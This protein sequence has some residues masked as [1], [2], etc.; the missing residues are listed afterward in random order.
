MLGAKLTAVCDPLITIGQIALLATAVS[1]AEPTASVRLSTSFSS[2]A[3]APAMTDAATTTIGFAH[4]SGHFTGLGTTMRFAE[5][6]VLSY[7]F[8]SFHTTM[9]LPA[10]CTASSEANLCSKERV[11]VSFTRSSINI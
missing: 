8:A 2:A 3:A 4:A 1:L 6:S 9:W 5:T 11:E 10:V 7:P